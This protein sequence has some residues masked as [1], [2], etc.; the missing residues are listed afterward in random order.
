MKIKVNYKAG[1]DMTFIVPQ[2]IL[3]IE[4]CRMAAMFGEVKSFSFL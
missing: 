3:A 1:K 4:F 2:D